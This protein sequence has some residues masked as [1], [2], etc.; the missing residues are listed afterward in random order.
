MPQISW[1]VVVVVVAA[2]GA[3]MAMLGLGATQRGGGVEVFGTSYGDDIPATIYMPEE[4]PEDPVPV[5]VLAHGY[6]ADRVGMSTLG[7]WL[8]RNG[9]GVVAFDVRGH[10]TN[11]RAFVGD[12]RDDLIAVLDSVD[13]GGD[14]DENRIALAGHSMG[15]FLVTDHASRDERIRATVALAGGVADGPLRPKNILFLVS[16]STDEDHREGR[17]TAA[18]IAGREVEDGEVVGDFAVGTAVGVDTVNTSVAMIIT[19]PGAGERTI[20]WLDQSLGIQRTSPVDLE[21]DRRPWLL[22]YAP[23]VLVLLYAVGRLVG[24]LAPERPVEPATR[25]GAGLLILLAALIAPMP[26]TGFVT[27]AAFIPMDV[28]DGLVSFFAL[29]GVALLAAAALLR[30]AP[31]GVF[32]RRLPPVIDTTIGADR[33]SISAVGAAALAFYLLLQPIGPFLHELVPTPKRLIIGAVVAAGLFVFTL[34]LERWL[35]RGS[36]LQAAGTS[37]AA[38]VLLII[39]LMVGAQLGT[40]PGFLLLVMPLF[41]VLFVVLEVFAAGVYAASRNTFVIAAANALVLAWIVTVFMP[42]RI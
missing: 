1:R 4:D 41:V 13:N 9:Y 18:D 7:R 10:G 38:R 33:A 28:A 20:R 35:R 6:S 31:E 34:P 8:A 3:V 23:C 14:F 32:A 16:S 40:I 24:R 42:V 39:T 2:F 27:P 26:I 37:I 29:A 5:V 21:Q 22:L 12:I 36:P 19:S 25:L 15:A 17:E 30:R 11:N